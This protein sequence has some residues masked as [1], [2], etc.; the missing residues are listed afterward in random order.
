MQILY[1]V[2]YGKFQSP[3]D[4]VT[5]QVLFFDGEEAYKDWTSLDSLY[6]SRHLADAWSTAPDINYPHSTRLKN[7]V[8]IPC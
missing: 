8:S 4:S 5:L 6:G 2:K 3:Q 1:T 7:I